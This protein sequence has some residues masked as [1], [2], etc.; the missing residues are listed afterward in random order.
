M[1]EQCKVGLDADSSL[2]ENRCFVQYLNDAESLTDKFS[3]VEKGN[4]EII[5][6]R[7]ITEQIEFI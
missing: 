1:Y 6:W 7:E 4:T 5:D 2:I 3:L